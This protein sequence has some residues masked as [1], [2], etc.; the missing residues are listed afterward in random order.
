[1]TK[2]GAGTFTLSG[3]NLYT[4]Q[5]TISAG[6]LKAGV[7]TNAF[8]DNSAI[9]LGNVSGAVLDLNGFNN[10]IG[11]LSGGGATGGNVS[12]GLASLSVGGD[13][14]STSYAGVISGV[15]GLIKAGNGTMTLSGSATYT[16][17]TTIS[18]GTLK[19]GVANTAFGVNSALTLSNMSGAV[20]GFKRIFEHDWFV[21]GGRSKWRERT[22]REER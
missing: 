9:V 11:S 8:G 20:L 21:I 3:T 2:T 12:L 17:A 15:G 19:A 6:T 22:S 18:A 7:A 10:T 16:G 5:T 1:L 13:G 4:G 14:T